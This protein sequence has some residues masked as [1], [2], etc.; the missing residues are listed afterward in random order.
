MGPLIRYGFVG[1]GFTITFRKALL[2]L[3]TVLILL[4]TVPFNSV[5]TCCMISVT[6]ILVCCWKVTKSAYKITEF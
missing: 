6:S 3:F 4:L 1:A 2:M 5:R